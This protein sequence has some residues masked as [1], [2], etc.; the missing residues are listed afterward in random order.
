MYVPAANPLIDEPDPPLLHAYVLVPVPPEAEAVIAP[1]L[2]PLQVRF[3]KVVIATVT[4]DA[5][6]VIVTLNGPVEQLF[7]S[8]TKTK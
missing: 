1:L 8:N 3:E 7:P 4:A 6:C 2:L 5:G